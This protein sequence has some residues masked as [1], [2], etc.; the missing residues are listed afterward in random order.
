MI[1]GNFNP[2]GPTTG[3]LLITVMASETI[4]AFAGSFVRRLCGPDQVRLKSVSLLPVFSIAAI[5]STLLYDV[6]TNVYT[7]L[8]WALMMGSANAFGSIL[9]ALTNP[10]AIF[11]SSVH[12]TSNVVAF[13]LLG[14][15]VIKGT[16]RLNRSADQHS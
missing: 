11:F 8:E 13:V 4:Y 10:G 3:S 12:I 9:I 7:G 15:I 1:Y 16:E 2:W 14:P 5:I 6:I